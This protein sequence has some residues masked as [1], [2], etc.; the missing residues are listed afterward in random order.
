MLVPAQ[1]LPPAATVALVPSGPVAG[2]HSAEQEL[3]EVEPIK[4]QQPEGQHQLQVENLFLY[5]NYIFILIIFLFA[6]SFRCA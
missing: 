6:F 2:F 3:G 5:G 1:P 4:L